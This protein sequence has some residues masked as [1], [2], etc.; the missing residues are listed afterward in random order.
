M[1]QI[2]KGMRQSGG[3][4]DVLRLADFAEQARQVILNARKQAA[5]IATDAQEKAQALR[6]EAT[7]QGYRQGFAR[8]QSEGYADGRGRADEEVRVR[9]AEEAN[10]L[11]DLARLILES[12]QASQRQMQQNNAE[13]GLE[14]ALELAGKIVGKLAVT[15]IEVARRN[16]AKA[17]ELASRSGGII[18]VQVNP[19]QLAQLTD[20]FRDFTEA[21]GLGRQVSMVGDLRVAPGGVKVLTARGEVDAT[22]EAQLARVADALLSGAKP[23]TPGAE[24]AYWPRQKS[25]DKSAMAAHVGVTKENVHV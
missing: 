19:E 3:G 17:L 14:F 12:L 7:D 10:E 22:V 20:R 11:A 16:L 9:L 6:Q 24:D 18:T 23:Q 1:T 2:I 15:D 25:P 13:E 8:G 21:M 5:K 4:A